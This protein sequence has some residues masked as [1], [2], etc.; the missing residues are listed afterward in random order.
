MKNLDLSWKCYIL[1]RKDL[2]PILHFNF[3]VLSVIL[4][5]L[6]LFTKMSLRYDL[7]LNSCLVKSYFPCPCHHIVSLFYP[8]AVFV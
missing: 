6:F 7:C 4:V 5:R 8:V 3:T 1:P 2:S